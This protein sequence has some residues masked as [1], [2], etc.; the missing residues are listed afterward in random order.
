MDLMRR[1]L[2]VLTSSLLA[3][4]STSGTPVGAGGAG[5]W[6]YEV[7]I[8]P[9]ASLLRVEAM[10]PPGTSEA[11]AIDDGFGA[12]VSAIDAEPGAGGWRAPRCRF[13]CRVRYQFDLAGAAARSRD[14]S[15]AEAHGGAIV[16]PASTWLVRPRIVP[17]GTRYRITVAARGGD[18]FA[19][20]LSRAGE[21]SPDSYEAD[22]SA[23][24]RGPF[25]VFGRFDLRA[26][27]VG[28]GI[29]DLA[30]LPG[31]FG[32][33]RD[34]IAAWVRSAAEN[35]TAYYG[36]FPVDRALVIIGSSEGQELSGG[37]TLGDG[38]AS[39]AM[40]VG[41]ATNA[42]TFDDDW[43][44]THEMVHLAFPNLPRKYHW[45]EEGVAVYVEPLARVLTGR[46][47]RADLWRDL[48][49]GLPNGLPASGDR[50]LDGT[51]TWGRTYWGGALFCF[52]ADLEIREKTNN[53]RSLKDALAGILARGGDVRV[54]WSLE[55]T[56]TEG[57]RAA[58]VNVLVPLHDRLGAAPVEIDLGAIWARLGVHVVKGDVELDDRAPLAETRR[59]MTGTA[60]DP[61]EASPRAG[62][63]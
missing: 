11:L 31:R 4:A 29:V 13:G 10:F 45:F 30:I 60:V 47:D 61:A 14:P 26:I 16:A 37:M 12:F 8:E 56:L 19:T 49:N 28:G 15:Y 54:A 7:E 33:G 44:M 51:P 36:R 24:S 20:G 38:G 34:A 52:L 35:V 6:R 21:G 59:A 5:L 25:S 23:L 22:A 32:V 39:I 17:R 48:A 55:K 62:A 53:R 42:R 2:P 46:F 18:R 63:R 43:K 41:E 9:G 57:D 27:E 1:A 58:G 50:G 3:C 40:S